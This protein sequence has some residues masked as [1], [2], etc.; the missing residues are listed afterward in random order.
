MICY[1]MNVGP[2]VTRVFAAGDGGPAVLL[3]HGFTSRADRFRAT[4]EAIAAKGYR[5]FVPDLPG[6]GFATK[7]PRHDHSI[8]GYRDFV[9]SLMDALGLERA[10]LIG[11]SLGG[12]VVGAVA[13]KV[14]ER[15]AALTM[16]GSLGLAPL[17]LERA[18]AMKAGLADM[19]L[20]A[21]RTRLLRV[22]CDPR[23]VTDQ[24]VLEDV[25]VN[26]S[27][28]AVASLSALADYMATRI[29]QDL[30]LDGFGALAGRFPL[31]LV[32]GEQDASVPVEVGRAARAALPAARLAVLAGANH[33]PYIER[34]D[35]FEPIILDLLAGQLGRFEAPDVTWV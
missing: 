17:P 23:F 30:V 26:T 8:G 24:L 15:V 18:H 16:I 20:A 28:G 25:K 11:T 10:S 3:I 35:L 1:P 14:P 13:C 31:L 6:H 7:D 19:S 32:W 12:H 2:V 4:A 5:V 22:F 27:P 33:T 9:I 21:M 29:N 34:P